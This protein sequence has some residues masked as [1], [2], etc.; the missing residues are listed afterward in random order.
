M[1]SW[2]SEHSP[3]TFEGLAIPEKLRQTLTS[4]SISATPPNFLITGP[5]GVGKTA[6]W[7]LVARQMLGPGWRATTHV[8]QCRDLAR[9]SGAMAKFE[10][11]LRPGGIDSSDTLAGRMS[12]D[13]FDRNIISTNSSDIAPAGKEIELKEGQLPVSRL[14]VLEDA[15]HLGHIRQAYLRRMM[16]TVGNASRF[17]LVARAPS[18]IIDALRSRTQ[19]IRI[20]YTSKPQLTEIL[21]SICAKEKIPPNEGVIGDIVYVCAGNL[22]KSIFTL[23]MLSSR[24]LTSDRAAVH[25]LV[26]ATTLQAGRHLLELA[27]RGKVV[28]WKWEKQNGKNRKILTGAIAEVDKLMNEHGLDSDDVVSQIHEVAIGRRLSITDELRCEILDALADCDTNLR[29]SM[30]ARIPIE[31]FLHRVAKAGRSHGL[32]FS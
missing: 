2:L 19:M 24:G 7:K 3:Q 10:N 22:R 13:A 14:I 26:Q 15:D 18:R 12:L 9:T 23:E 20:P 29:N 25:K 5:A 1:A 11:F 21:E 6:S 17:I 27:L 31:H 28:E 4:A 16:E 32:A 30:H 8:L